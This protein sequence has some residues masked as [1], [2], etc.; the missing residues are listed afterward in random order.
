MTFLNEVLG[1]CQNAGLHVIA[2]VCDMGANS[3]KASKLLGASRQKPFFTLR[4]QDIV[5]VYDPPHFLKCTGNLFLNDK[6]QFEPELMC[7]QL[8]VIAKLQHILNA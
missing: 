8:P 7:N 2:T 5:T 3:V 1:A 6:V 4:N